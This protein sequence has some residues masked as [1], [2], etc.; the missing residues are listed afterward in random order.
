M[1]DSYDPRV[2]FAAERTLLAWNR[3]TISFMAFGFVIERFGL[4]LEL[5]NH[6]DITLFERHLSFYIGVSFIMLA[7]IFSVY[8]LK[9]FR[10]LL[11]TL[12]VHDIPAGYDLK[13]AQY[14]N[15]VAAVLALALV[16]YLTL[17]FA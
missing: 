7:A 5:L 14:P 9:Q 10:R 4:A 11:K 6:A 13:F 3:T 12:P 2:L 15:A 17:G 16:V 1:A 8:S